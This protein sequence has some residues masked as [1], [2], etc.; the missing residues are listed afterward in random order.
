MC[1]CHVNP[2]DDSLCPARP[3]GG[4]PSRRYFRYPTFAS[5]RSPQVS[6]VTSMPRC[7]QRPGGLSGE[8]THLPA[9]D[10]Y[11]DSRRESSRPSP[12]ALEESEA[13]RARQWL[14]DCWVA[15]L[16][17]G[18]PVSAHKSSSALAAV[19]ALLP[20]ET[21]AT[22]RRSHRRSHATPRRAY[23]PDGSGRG[24]PQ[25]HQPRT[26]PVHDERGCCRA[27][28]DGKPERL[29]RPREKHPSPRLRLRMPAMRGGRVLCEAGDMR[30]S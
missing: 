3:A 17:V 26:P 22:S 13:L 4:P 12:S 20:A 28:V 16:V 19:C 6:L 8:G 14:G 1:L 11:A 9:G 24:A 15:P 25:A 5:A 30:F 21:G 2:E 29:G 23:R 18:G 27:H 7:W 10:E